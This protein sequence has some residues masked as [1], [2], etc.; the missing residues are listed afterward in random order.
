AQLVQPGGHRGDAGGQVGR[1]VGG[2]VGGRG[3]AGARGHGRG[4]GRSGG[5][6]RGEHAG[7]GPDGGPAGDVA[8]RVTA[9]P[10]RDGEQPRTGERRVLVHLPPSADVGTC[11]ETKH[12]V[13]HATK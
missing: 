10:V 6:V 9:H 4:G 8:V 2:G 7:Q 3:R 13:S 12:M 1:G 5:R 11:G